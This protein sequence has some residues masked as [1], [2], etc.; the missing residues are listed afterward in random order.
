MQQ[1]IHCLRHLVTQSQEQM[2]VLTQFKHPDYL[3]SPGPDYTAHRL[4][5]PAGLNSDTRDQDIKVFDFLIIHSRHGVLV[6]LSR[7]S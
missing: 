2:F 6:G 7:D 3:K 4:P 5:L 1:V